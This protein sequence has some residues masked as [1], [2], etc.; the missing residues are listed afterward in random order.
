MIKE[1]IQ[2]TTQ[3]IESVK[4]VDPEAYQEHEIVLD[5]LVFHMRLVID[6][7]ERRQKVA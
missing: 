7:L 3:L 4:K 5:H 2:Q 1:S 6:S